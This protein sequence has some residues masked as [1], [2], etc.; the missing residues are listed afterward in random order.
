MKYWVIASNQHIDSFVVRDVGRKDHRWYVNG[1]MR[2]MRPWLTGQISWWV[3]VFFTWTMV[4]VGSMFQE[5]LISPGL[6]CDVCLCW[7][8]KLCRYRLWLLLWQPFT[9]HRLALGHVLLW[10]P[11]AKQRKQRPERAI[12]S[13]LS[14][15]DNFL[16]FSRVH[17]GWFWSQ[18]STTHFFGLLDVL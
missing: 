6:S 11:A 5:L 10:W 13:F 9:P 4:L 14:D 2:R 1:L 16:N 18:L 17:G 12:T 3:L 8:D 7:N 15:T